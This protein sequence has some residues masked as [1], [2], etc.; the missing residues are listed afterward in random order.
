MIFEWS[1]HSWK[2]HML[3]QYDKG[4]C[5]KATVTRCTAID[6]VASYSGKYVAAFS[7]HYARK[8]INGNRDLFAG[9]SHVKIN[10]SQSTG[11]EIIKLTSLLSSP[12]H[13]LHVFFHHV[14]SFYQ[15]NESHRLRW[16]EQSFLFSMRSSAS[17]FSAIHVWRFIVN[18]FI[19][20]YKSKFLVVDRTIYWWH[21][22]PQSFFSRVPIRQFN[23][24][25][26]SYSS[27]GGIIV[28]RRSP[29]T[30]HG[31]KRWHPRRKSIPAIASTGDHRW[32]GLYPTTDV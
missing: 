28:T 15:R 31:R 4:K 18:R 29:T 27:F 19:S 20:W 10:W 21:E 2:L 23:A 1:G 30:S 9:K 16:R 5:S 32:S 14:E 22:W 24:V 25:P 7:V 17:T 8:R 13:F 3:H 12:Q 26:K 6:D 11:K